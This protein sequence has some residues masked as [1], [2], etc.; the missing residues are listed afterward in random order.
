[1]SRCV[2]C[3]FGAGLFLAS[4]PAGPAAAEWLRS[5]SQLV[6]QSGYLFGLARHCGLDAAGPLMLETLTYVNIHEPSEAGRRQAG[7]QF[8][9]GSEIARRDLSDP[10]QDTDCAGLPERLEPRLE[11]LRRA[12]A[13]GVKL[14]P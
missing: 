12:N 8:R 14:A 6:G 2:E 3:L 13:A 5:D 10:S 4:L 9:A 11:A 1:M 7:Q